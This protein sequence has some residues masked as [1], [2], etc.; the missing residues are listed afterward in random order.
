MKKLLLYLFLLNSGLLLSQQT[1]VFQKDYTFNNSPFNGADRRFSF[2]VPSDYNPSQSYPLILGLHACG[3]QSNA[4]RNRLRP[5]ADS[6]DAIVACPDAN[7]DAIN[8]EFNGREVELLEYIYD[9][10]S[11]WY[12]ID[13]QQIYLTGFSCNGREAL[14]IALEQHTSIPIAG[15]LPYAGAFNSPA[16]DASSFGRTSVTPACFCMGDQDIFYTQMSFYQ[17]VL[18]S[19][20]AQSANYHDILMPGVGHT[21]AHAGFTSYMLD[22]FEFLSNNTTISLA[23]STATNNFE[24]SRTGPLT[25][26]I[27]TSLAGPVTYEVLDISGKLLNSEEFRENTSVMLSN[28]GIYILVLTAPNGKIESLKIGL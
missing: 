2:Y 4:F 25:I 21:T 23:E 22:C 26:E 7:G 5:I 6:L 20:S 14:Y 15:V 28:P 11:T 18:D 19:M 12:N 3:S 10:A 8:N 16:I 24:I 1:G 27:Q 17:W 9:S 13:D